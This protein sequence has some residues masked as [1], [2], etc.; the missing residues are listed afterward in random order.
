MIMISACLLGKNCKYS[1]GNN[2]NPCLIDLLKD[3][4]TLPVCPEELGSLPTPRPPAEIIKGNGYDVLHG[5]ARICTKDGGDV[6]E[7][8]LKGAE[9]VKKLAQSHPINLAI[10]KERSP[11][12]G[13]C[14]IYDGTFSGKTI[15][16]LGVCTALLKDLGI[17][18]I[19]EE[20][21]LSP[22]ILT[23]IKESESSY[24]FINGFS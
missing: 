5:L 19:S 12:C 22:E 8:F 6:T 23:L 4:K 18:V 15:P 20:S 9:A 17:T 1:G 10:M 7:S 21:P 13:V 3:K 14:K 11:S 2:E 24:P 16:G